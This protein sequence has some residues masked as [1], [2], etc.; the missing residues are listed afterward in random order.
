MK[1]IS[2]PELVKIDKIMMAPF[3]RYVVPDDVA[4]N[5]AVKLTEAKVDYTC[6]SF[7]PYEKRYGGQEARGKKLAFFRHN[8]WGD[9]LMATAVVNVLQ[10]LRP[11]LRVDVYCSPVVQSMWE[12]VTRSYP[13]PMLFD[14]IKSYDY[15]VFYEGMLENNWEPDQNNAIDDMIQFLGI[16]PADVPDTLKRPTV[17]IKESDYNE[18]KELKM[19]LNVPYVVVQLQA[20]NPN[21]TYP[22]RQT[23]QLCRMIMDTWRDTHVILVGL[24]PKGSNQDGIGTLT[25]YK[26]FHNLVNKLNEFRS[27]IPLVKHAK[28]VVCPDSSIGHL[29]GAFSEVPTVSLWGLFNPDDRVKYYTNHLPLFN[30]GVCPHAPCHNHQFNLPQ[31][32]CKDAINAAQGTQNYCNALKSITPD[33]IMDKLRDA[34][35]TKVEITPD[36]VPSQPLVSVI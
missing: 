10:T 28:A 6:S 20:S 25:T 34:F 35:T 14:A 12:G 26:R 32:K 8:A 11:E 21:R 4:K 15:H 27:V 2:S 30:D 36:P 31:E 17:V 33:Q 9:Q 22:P 13:A 18:V 16:D 3:A 29:S 7:H 5:I 1:L 19:N 24:D 23:A